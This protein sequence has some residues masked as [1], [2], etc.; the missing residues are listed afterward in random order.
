M[1]NLKLE[2]T[3][4]KSL[5]WEYSLPAIAGNIIF[6]LYNIVD[7]IFI[8]RG[9]GREAI[10]GV[11]ITLPIFTLILAISLFIGIGSAV[12]ISISLG[13]KNTEKAEKT[14]GLAIFLFIFIGVIF[15]IFG[16][17]FI[18]NILDMFGATKNTHI[19]AKN[20]MKYI[21]FAAPFQFMSIGLNNIIRGEG[22]PK[23]A[24]RMNIIGAIL[25]IVLD[26][27]LMFKLKMGIEGAALATV[28]ANMTVSVFQIYHFMFGKSKI[29]IKKEFIKIEFKLL[30]KLSSIG[31]SPFLMQL[32]NSLV[33]IF[34]NKNLKIY[35]GDIAI[36]SFGIVN[37][38]NTLVYM[39]IVGMYQ[40]S[41]PIIGYN[42]GAEKYLRVR[43]TFM[44][45]L[46]IAFTITV[47]GYIL[48]MI[49]PTFLINFFVKNDIELSRLTIKAI[50]IFFSMLF[51]LGINTIGIGYFQTIG[52]ANI[53]AILNF[54]KQ[55]VFMLG[56]LY[57]LP[58]KYGVDGVWVSAPVTEFLTFLIVIWFIIFE[59]KNLKKMEVKR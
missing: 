51:L 23:V 25:N 27:I 1:E 22:S 26:P 10:A 47:L 46:K 7:R 45:V 56:M 50:R 8:S 34:I 44:Q 55:I 15:S 37:S 40:G 2:K 9:L 24:M 5:I 57:I 42:Y 49:F 28:I 59:L 30:V 6:I 13:K 54:L 53:T 14:L 41:Q 20:Y 32:S 17:Y 12:I 29:K 21:F 19:Y 31:I 38:V 52:R 4:I 11:S 48:V 39:P 43:E 3:D 36:A 33:V 35:G 18:D 16:L 58:K